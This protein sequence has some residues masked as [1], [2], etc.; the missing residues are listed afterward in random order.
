MAGGITGQSTT[1]N[2]PNFVGELFGLT[3]EDTPFLSMAGGLSGGKSVDATLWGWQTYDLRD[4]S[5]PSVLEGANAPTAEARVRGWEF[6]VVQIHHETRG[7]ARARASGKARA[8]ASASAPLPANSRLPANFGVRG[9]ETFFML[10]CRNQMCLAT[11]R[12]S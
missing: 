6:N 9:V 3:P 5:Q 1:F 11:K 2:L 12:P 8:R 10:M 7:K 4:A